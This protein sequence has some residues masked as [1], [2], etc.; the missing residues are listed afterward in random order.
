M[1]MAQNG[2]VDTLHKFF[3]YSIPLKA[4]EHY[5]YYWAKLSTERALINI[6]QA[7]RHIAENARIC[8]LFSFFFC[9]IGRE[10]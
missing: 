1:F 7:C 2:V 8:I 9:F 6:S 4:A 10:C 5:M 3:D